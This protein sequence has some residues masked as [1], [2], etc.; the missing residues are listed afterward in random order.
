MDDLRKRTEPSE[1]EQ[2]RRTELMLGK[3]GLDALRSSRVMVVGLGAVGSYAVE[4][5]A[6]A[7]V[8]R[9]R[10]VDFDRIQEEQYQCSCSRPI[11]CWKVEDGR[12][13]ANVLRRLIRLRSSRQKR[14]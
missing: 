2:F 11:F 13:S 4:A 10:L 1:T 6:R 12:G 14:F 9:F 8:G 3:P 7:G 5:L